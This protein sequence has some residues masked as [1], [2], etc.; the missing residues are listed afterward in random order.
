MSEHHFQFTT[1]ASTY[2]TVEHDGSREEAELK[3][4]DQLPGGLCHHCS[5]KAELG[6][7]ELQPLDEEV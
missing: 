6:D 5:S 7:W 3:A 2:V 4:Y 1:T